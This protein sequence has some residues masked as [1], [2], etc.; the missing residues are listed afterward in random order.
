M[1]AST[2]LERDA[3]YYPYI[4]IT[5]INWLKSTL[6]CFP[7]VRRM[8][9]TSYTPDD[10][11]EVREFCEVTGPRGMPLLTSV[12][13][14]SPGASR[15]ELNLLARLQANDSFIR[16]RYSRSKTLQQYPNPANYFI[17]HDEKIISQLCNYLVG[18]EGNDDLAWRTAAPPERPTRSNVGQ[19]LALHPVLGRA[20][21]SVKAISI[22]DEFGLDIVTDSSFVHHSVVS[23]TE[24]D[25]FEELIGKPAAH[26]DPTP[27]DTLD[28]LAEVVMATNFD[29]SRLS[30]KQIADLLSDGKDLRKFKDELIP[31]AAS[32]PTI[33]EPKERAQR[34][35]AAADEVSEKWNKYRKSLP[36]FALE[37]LVDA[38][39]VKWPDVANS[40][41]LG[42]SSAVMI[43]S[44]IGLGIF[45]VSYSGVKI[46][47]KYKE[48]SSSP[49]AYLN[50]IAKA[51]GESGSFLSLP[52][53]C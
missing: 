46:W 21:L 10:S 51:Q 43:G 44:G 28:D 14:F 37:A 39:E 38:T 2:A 19:W 7:N 18:S 31:I 4:H 15:A 25:T 32:I 9:P 42:G 50:R 40:L 41:I 35:K 13:L 27:D 16:S 33:K 24:D 34:L 48:V 6:L 45:L 29:V 26:R 5:D 30:A 12:N 17:L 53:L 1:A 11:K 47:R 52:P 8:V 36:R 23:T 49:Y 22:A 20:I 3:L